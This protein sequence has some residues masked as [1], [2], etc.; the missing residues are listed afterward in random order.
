VW[1][2]PQKTP[3]I[4]AFR[5]LRWWLT[6]VVTAMTWSGSV[7][8]RIPRKNPTAIM[9]KKLI[10]EGAPYSDCS[11]R[12]QLVKASCKEIKI[13]THPI[14][15]FGGSLLGFFSRNWMSGDLLT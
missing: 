10:T 1:P 12:A 11:R 4:A 7:A 14:S 9:E 13:L 3:V 15:C 6:I 5:R 2:I 8:W